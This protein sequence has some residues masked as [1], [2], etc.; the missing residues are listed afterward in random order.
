MQAVTRDVRFSADAEASSQSG[1]TIHP[2]RLNHWPQ[3]DPLESLAGAHPQDDMRVMLTGRIQVEPGDCPVLRIAHQPVEITGRYYGLVQFVAPLEGSDRFQVNHF[4][5]A[6]RQFNGASEVVRLPPVLKAP[7]YD[8]YASTTQGLEQSPL[9][10]TGWYIYGTKD[11]AGVFVVQA[12]APRSLLRLQPDRVVFG[13]KAAYRYIRREAWAKVAD[14]KGRIASVLCVGDRTDQ[15]S[16]A[17]IA[18][19]QVGDRALVLHIYGGIGGQQREPGA[20]S[21]LYFGHFAY[22]LA[23]V[24]RDPLSQDL[25]FDIRYY[26]VYS[27]NTDGLTAGTLHWS[28]YLGDRQWGWLGNRP[29]CDLVVKCEPLT[30]AFNVNQQRRSP[31]TDM[32]TQLEGMTARYRIGDGTGATYVGPANN[33]AQ[34]SNQ[35]LFASIRSLERAM[36]QHQSLLETWQSTDPLQFQRYQQLLTLKAQLRRLL[37]PL[38]A[39][40]ADWQANEFNLGS[41]LEDQPLRNLWTGLGSWRTLLPRKASDAIVRVFLQQGA[42]VWVLR[43]NQVGGYD[44]EIEPIAP[45]TL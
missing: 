44:P 24:I 31:L 4:N 23:T 19:W 1:D 26:Q 2:D 41:T 12:L 37:Q 21:P 43:T 33:C 38:G 40:R 45:I 36:A 30:G 15:N 17:A 9:N 28:R 35:A 20:K 6:S 7:V 14:Q 11:Q 16:Q 29:V 34:D 42:T 39:P 8:S 5:A 27:H 18:E 10:E 3:V 22:G 32:L 13:A 25:R